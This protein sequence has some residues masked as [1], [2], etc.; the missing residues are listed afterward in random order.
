[1]NFLPIITWYNRH[2]DVNYE[3]VIRIDSRMFNEE[4][5]TYIVYHAKWISA[6]HSKHLFALCERT[7][8]SSSNDSVQEE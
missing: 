1:M 6:F 4:S 7:S 5:Y 8:Q 3:N 2:H